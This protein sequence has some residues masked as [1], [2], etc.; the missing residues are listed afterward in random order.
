M[1]RKTKKAAVPARAAVA[2]PAHTPRKGFAVERGVIVC[3]LV[4]AAIGCIAYANSLN[5]KLLWDDE[6]LVKDNL[7]LKSWSK[8]SYL[9]TESIGTGAGK[10]FGFYRPIQSLT[11]M[12]DYSLWRLNP[13]GYHLQ[14]ALWHIAASLCVFVLI[15]ILYGDLFLSLVTGLLFAVHPVHTEAV[16]YVSG[17]A[18]PICLVFMLLTFIF[19][20]KEKPLLTAATYVL[21]ILSRENVIILPFLILL[22]HFTFR[23]KMQPVSFSAMMALVVGYLICRVT[24]LQYLL[25][26]VTSGYHPSFLDRL[27]GSFVA[28]AKYVR[29]LFLPFGLHMEY[30]GKLFFF[31][32]PGALIGI[33]IFIASLV[34]LIMKARTRSLVFFGVAWFYIAILPVSNVF[35]TINAYM[36][37]HWL[38][39]P[40]IGFFL[41]IAHGIQRLY[42]SGTF[43]T[44]AIAILACL[45]IFYGV[46][47]MKQNYYWK[48]PL[49]FYE[50]T[51]HYAPDS[52]TVN[53]D[54]GFHYYHMNRKEEAIAAFKKVVALSPQYAGAYNNLANTYRDLGKNEEAIA[55]YKKTIEIDPQSVYP[56][57]NLG[58][59]YRAMGKKDEAIEAYKEAVRVNPRF[60]DAYNN[61]ASAY[62]DAGNVEEAVRWYNLA[63]EKNPQYAEAYNH[64]GILYYNENKNKEAIEYFKKALA[65]KPDF[66]YAHSNIAFAYYYERQYDLAAAHYEEALR[67]GYAVPKAFIP[68]IEPY[69]KR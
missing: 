8:I 57:N 37:E 61:L 54:L 12:V 56:F 49:V 31:S 47:T 25:P 42:E 20:I 2:K 5:G 19:Y 69:R 64:L 63:I 67:L 36:A 59:T 14:S 44:L 15:Y 28:L 29:L 30:G 41:I 53:N 3:L 43:K 40:S 24:V 22:Y 34:F 16:S 46:L 58:N 27:P 6:A 60:I 52:P 1:K 62:Y 50:K 33:G 11:Y 39:V 45:V 9:F 7:F 13:F 4:I 55:L 26:H 35:Y 23:R 38:Y 48:E 10:S 18:D 65:L 32:D 17:R 51:L 66:G 68:L 21:A